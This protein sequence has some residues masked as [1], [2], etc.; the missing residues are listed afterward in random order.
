MQHLHEFNACVNITIGVFIDVLNL[1]F[2]EKSAR[3]VSTEESA[4]EVSAE[5]HA[6]E[7]SA[8]RQGSATGD[9]ITKPRE[10]II[11]NCLQF[12]K[13]LTRYISGSL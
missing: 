3:E 11:S 13:F 2:R 10:K 12:F 5:K 6:R 9:T 8:G 4:G 7:V 1:I